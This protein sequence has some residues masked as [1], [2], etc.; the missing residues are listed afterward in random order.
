MHGDGA[1]C[2]RAEDAPLF[3]LARLVG[4]EDGADQHDAFE[5]LYKNTVYACVP[6][7]RKQRYN[8]VNVLMLGKRNSR[9][10][11]IRTLILGWSGQGLGGESWRR[12]QDAE[13]LLLTNLGSC[14]Q[15]D[16]ESAGI[17]NLPD[18]LG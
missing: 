5:T 14:H 13:R 1:I 8:A 10:Q 17:L 4:S 2:A 3:G 16:L 6:D 11:R 18:A 15:L 9:A 7:E 12:W